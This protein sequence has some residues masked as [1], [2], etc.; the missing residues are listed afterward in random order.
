[1][2][3]KWLRPVT[4]SLL[5]LFMAGR[6]AFYTNS[7]NIIVLCLSSRWYFSYRID[8]PKVRNVV[9]YL[10]RLNAVNPVKLIRRYKLARSVFS[11]AVLP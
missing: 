9:A 4:V 3:G 6:V 10:S 5:L 2:L 11:S 8:S 1:M 7:S